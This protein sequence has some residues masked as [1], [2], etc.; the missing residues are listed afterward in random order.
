MYAHALDRCGDYIEARASARGAFEEKYGARA[1]AFLA[2]LHPLFLLYRRLP[3]AFGLPLHIRHLAGTAALYIAEHQDFL[4]DSKI[5][6][7]GLIDDVYV[8]FAALRPILNGAGD[9]N[10]GEHWRGSTPLDD[11]VGMAHNLDILLEA[12]PMKVR[13][14]AD[15]LLGL[16]QD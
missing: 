15:K 3:F 11:V 14:N 8:A 6:G 13:Q 9:V 4:D 1:G 16:N 5:E 2:E 10:V 7:V 12:V